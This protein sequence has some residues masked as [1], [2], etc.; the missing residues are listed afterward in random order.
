MRIYSKVQK[1]IYSPFRKKENMKFKRLYDLV[2]PLVLLK[3]NLFGYVLEIL[4][5]ISL[6][7]EVM[8]VNKKVKFYVKFTIV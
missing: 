3:A 7:S 5:N 4:N 8:I 2:A 6:I 1:N